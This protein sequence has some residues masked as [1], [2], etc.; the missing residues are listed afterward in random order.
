MARAETWINADGLEVGFGPVVGNNLTAGPQEVKGK[1]KQLQ[2]DINVAVDGLPASG[3]AISSKESPI[4]AGA[5][6]VN[7]KYVADVDFDF[8]V[9]F[10]VSQADGTA[11]D[12]DGLIAET[13]TTAV[14]AGALVGTVLSQAAYIT[15]E[16]GPTAG[17][18]ATV[19]EG[20][21]LVEYII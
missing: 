21:V 19:G 8:G 17:G 6:I 11:I 5:Y 20:T 10:G 16:D 3:T 7:V 4:P 13:T 1:I 12:A 18:P 2:K 15:A 9:I 14:G